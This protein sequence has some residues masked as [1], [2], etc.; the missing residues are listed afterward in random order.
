MAHTCVCVC[1]CVCVRVCWGELTL[2]SL[3]RDHKETHFY[4]DPDP[5][6]TPNILR[7]GDSGIRPE[8]SGKLGR[9][10]R[11]AACHSD[12]QTT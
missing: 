1:V 3:E 2:F 4:V 8:E 11:W 7:L 5:N 9:I 10:Q 12:A 6:L